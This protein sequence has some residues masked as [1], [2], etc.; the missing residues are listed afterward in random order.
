[1]PFFPVFIDL[2]KKKVLVV[3]GGRVATRKVKNL[4]RFTEDITVVAPKVTRELDEIYREGRIRL[5]RRRFLAQDLKEADVVI[6]AVDNVKL[7]ER[8]YR[9]CE[10]RGILCNSV[11]SPEFCN[12]L[13]P[14]LVIRGDLVIGISSSGKVPALSRRVREIVERCLPESIE[15]V[16][17]EL[18]RERRRMEKG[19]ERQRRITK[20][21]DRLLP[22]E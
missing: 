8:I 16:L 20:L 7:Q 1:M 21:V 11:D 18:S 2:S 17:E 15:E 14:S 12:F 10:R 19:E 9:L 6:V 13:F 3:G 5:K 22:L 4:L